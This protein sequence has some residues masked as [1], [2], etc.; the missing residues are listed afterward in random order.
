MDS[1]D[2]VYRNLIDR[3]KGVTDH[4]MYV[5]NDKH[6]IDINSRPWR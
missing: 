4:Y 1:I 3:L 6:I 2:K 5:A